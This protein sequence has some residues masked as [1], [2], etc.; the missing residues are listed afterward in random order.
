VSICP[1]CGDTRLA[2]NPRPTGQFDEGDLYHCAGCGASGES[3]NLIERNWRILCHHP[4]G[5]TTI[6][7]GLFTE[8]EADAKATRL[9]RFLDRVEVEIEQIQEAP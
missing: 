2:F 7:P 3:T 8:A 5:H 4:N 9:A 1:D 6:L